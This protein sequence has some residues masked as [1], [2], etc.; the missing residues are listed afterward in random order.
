MYKINLIKSS[1]NKTFT[2]FAK[3]G[4]MIDSFYDSIISKYYASDFIIESWGNGK[5]GLMPPS[6]E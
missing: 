4:K 2:K 6:C 1:N 5:N 3:N